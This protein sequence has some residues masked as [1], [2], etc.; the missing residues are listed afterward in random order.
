MAEVNGATIIYHSYESGKI[1]GATE[2]TDS[3]S[4]KTLH[5]HA[6]CRYW[7]RI[8]NKTQDE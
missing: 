1:N 3:P 6:G 4:I 7:L 8:E 2:Y 5:D